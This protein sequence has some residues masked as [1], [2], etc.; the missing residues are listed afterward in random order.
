MLS[1]TLAKVGTAEE[2]WQP[3]M[4]LIIMNIQKEKGIDHLNDILIV[5]NLLYM[6]ATQ[7]MSTPD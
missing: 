1:F 2:F 5:T 3:L 4:S 6:L 7:E